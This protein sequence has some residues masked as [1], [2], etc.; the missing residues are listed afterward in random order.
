MIENYIWET[1]KE[2][3]SSGAIAYAEKISE[4]LKQTRTHTEKLH[5]HYW[6]TGTIGEIAGHL[7]LIN[8][9]IIHEWDPPE[10]NPYGDQWDY[11]IGDKTIDLKVERSGH[12]F[13]TSDYVLV[14]KVAEP[15]PIDYYWFALWNTNDNTITFLGYVSFSEFYAHP[16]LKEFTKGEKFPNGKEVKVDCYGLQVKHLNKSSDILS[17]RVPEK[18]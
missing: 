16:E 11:K 15:K 7:I 13:T 9:G 2:Q 3:L 14:K 6:K 4:T 1:I 8:H 17:G 5:E 12:D 18:P 10:N